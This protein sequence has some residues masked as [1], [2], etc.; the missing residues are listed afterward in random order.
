MA[1]FPAMPVTETNMINVELVISS[2]AVMD[3]SVVVRLW[4]YCHKLFIEIFFSVISFLVT[5]GK[6]EYKKGGYNL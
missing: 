5:S 6:R 2:Q 1:C 4:R 3:T